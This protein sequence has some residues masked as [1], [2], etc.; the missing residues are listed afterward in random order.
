MRTTEKQIQLLSQGVNVEDMFIS[1][2]WQDIMFEDFITSSL[3]WQKNPISSIGSYRS[4][5][6]LKAG[7]FVSNR[8]YRINVPQSIFFVSGGVEAGSMRVKNNN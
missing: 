4:N 8:G 1:T 2:N 7:I 6:K 3:S 5:G